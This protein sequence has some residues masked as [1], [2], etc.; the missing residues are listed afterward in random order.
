MVKKKHSLEIVRNFLRKIA[1]LLHANRTDD[2]PINLHE[3]GLHYRNT[4]AVVCLR[5]ALLLAEKN[6][7]ERGSAIGYLEVVEL[8]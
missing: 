6:L 5:V 2:S 7:T 1:I 3:F 8:L 4:K